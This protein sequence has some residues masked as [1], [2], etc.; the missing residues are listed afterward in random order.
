MKVFSVVL[1]SLFL[2]IAKGA[3]PVFGADINGLWTKTTSPDPN[4]IAIFYSEKKDFKAMGYSE[5]HR[6]KTV[7][8]A[9]GKIKGN[10]LHCYY[11]HPQDAVP[12]GW[13]QEGLMEL[14]ISDD[15]DE[16]TGIAKSISGNWSGTIS[17]VRAR[18][19]PRV[20]E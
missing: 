7:W 1:A 14:T 15:G 4:N 12:P 20:R 10:I 5:I 6:R 3:I 11:R 9:E 13:E 19:F 16:I 8:Y 2:L 18:L 17:F